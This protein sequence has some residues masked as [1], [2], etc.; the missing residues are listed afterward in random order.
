MWTACLR[1]EPL[2]QLEVQEV[3]DRLFDHRVAANS[4]DALMGGLRRVASCYSGNEIEP[5]E[6]ETVS[7]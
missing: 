4:I 6:C 1:G 3:S 2:L 7:M 5:S